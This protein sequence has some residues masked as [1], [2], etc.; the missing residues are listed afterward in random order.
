MQEIGFKILYFWNNV[1]LCQGAIRFLLNMWHADETENFYVTWNIS[2]DCHKLMLEEEGGL[3]I[4]Y[5]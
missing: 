4:L 5:L 2:I 1:L 3:I